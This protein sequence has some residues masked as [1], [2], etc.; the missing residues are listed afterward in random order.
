MSQQEIK[1]ECWCYLLKRTVQIKG[2]VE[3]KRQATLL[4]I[5]HCELETMC[6]FRRDRECLVGKL[7]EGRW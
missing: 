3:G 5:T 6:A 7:R 2:N 4:R 1:S